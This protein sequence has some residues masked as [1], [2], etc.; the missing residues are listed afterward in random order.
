LGQI[1]IV[2]PDDLENK[3]RDDCRIKGDMSR[4]VT[5]ALQNYYKPMEVI[6]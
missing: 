2:I 4:L 3:V 5:K 1:T 6:D